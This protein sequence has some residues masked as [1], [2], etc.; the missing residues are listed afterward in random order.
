VLVHLIDVSSGSGR[1]PV[2]DF[3]TIRNELERF[4]AS[5]P[6]AAPGGASGDAVT[7]TA[8]DLA[9]KPQLAAAT[10]M[11]ALDDDERLARLKGHLR[12]RSVPL[13]PIS[14]VT[15]DGVPALLEAMWSTIH[16][17]GE[18]ARFA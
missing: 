15:G 7:A 5:A 13:Y 4:P 12:A 8:P 14:A 16:G 6:V 9:R 10:K 18:E 2:D 3:E 17:S 1:D 11:D